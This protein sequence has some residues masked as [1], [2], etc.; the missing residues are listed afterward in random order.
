MT[1]G[2]HRHLRLGQ[3]RWWSAPSPQS[4]KADDQKRPTE[5]RAGIHADRWRGRGRRHRKG[6]TTAIMSTRSGWVPTPAPRRHRHR[7]QRVLRSCFQVGRKP[8]AAGQGVL[9]QRSPRAV[10][11][12]AG[13]AG[14]GRE[15]RDRSGA[16]SASP[17]DVVALRGGAGLGTRTSTCRPF[18][19]NDRQAS[20]RGRSRSPASA[21]RVVRRIF[22]GCGLL[23]P[24]P[25]ER[26]GQF[27]KKS[28][29]TC[30]ST[31]SRPRFKG[32]RHQPTY[33]GL[34]PR[35]PEVVPA[36]DVGRDAAAHPGIR[37]GEGWTSPPV[38]EVRG[39]RLSR[40]AVS[41]SRGSHRRCVAIAD[42]APG[43]MGRWPRRARWRRGARQAGHTLDSFGEIGPATLAHGPA[44]TL[45][46]AS[47]AHQDGPHI[48][49][50]SPMSP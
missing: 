4:R 20:T 27:T 42:H 30:Y 32:R 19:T 24:G 29:N 39:T 9:L 7:L 46:G 6:L 37:G 14:A 44:G 40:A 50:S 47:A 5:P 16:D 1:V 15:D 33:E 26:Q 48:G 34:I 10:G 21:W 23:R 22:N 3:S 49:S 35:G 36:K 12:G 11:A 25:A 31:R 2:V 18:S 17:A 8:Y 41:T 45:S 13:H 43:R 38:P 28:S